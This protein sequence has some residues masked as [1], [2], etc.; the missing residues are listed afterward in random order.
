MIDKHTRVPLRGDLRIIRRDATDAGILSVWEKKN[1]ITY[2]GTEGLVYL[3]APN[4]ALGAGIQEQTQIKSMRFG[5]S[6][7]TP[8]RTDIGLTA[9]ATVASVPVR[10]QLSDANRIIG[11]SGTV[12]FVANMASG[13]GNG[14][15][16]REAG[17]FTRGTDDDPQIAT[18]CEMFSRQI[19][20]D[21]VKNAA[22]TLE[23]RWR[24]TFTV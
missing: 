9:E 14:N 12:E 6:S 8:Q 13:Y 23:F 2:K 10:V 15:T 19:F 18:S 3:L 17:L 24:I 5:T 7:A 22:V 21:Q 1:V 11:V 4:A 20:P 16:Y